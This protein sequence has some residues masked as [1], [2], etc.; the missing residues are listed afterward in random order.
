[1]NNI[2]SFCLFIGSRWVYFDPKLLFFFFSPT[3]RSS[4][5]GQDSGLFV[6]TGVQHSCPWEQPEDSVQEDGRTGQPR[7]PGH[8]RHAQKGS[9]LSLIS[10]TFFFPPFDKPTTDPLLTSD[11]WTS[12]CLGLFLL[13]HSESVNPAMAREK[14]FYSTSTLTSR[15][16]WNSFLSPYFICHYLRVIRGTWEQ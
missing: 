8:Q 14:P 10:E 11:L 16:S 13:I 3:A 7:A 5:A 6:A 15:W 2:D 12:R 4:H 9:R 1:M